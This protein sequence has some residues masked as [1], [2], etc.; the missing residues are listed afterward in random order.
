MRPERHAWHPVSPLR[1]LASIAAV[2]PRRLP[3]WAPAKKP[4][5]QTQPET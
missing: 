4:L 2:D 1:K 5:G 3:S